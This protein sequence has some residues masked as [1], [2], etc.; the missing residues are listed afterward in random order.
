MEGRGILMAGNDTLFKELLRIEKI[1][2]YWVYIAIA[3]NSIPVLFALSDSLNGKWLFE[4]KEHDFPQQIEYELI[5]HDFL[6]ARTIGLINGK[7]I[8]DEYAMKKQ[9]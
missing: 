1:G 6:T 7:L 9:N 8:V 2:N 4:N 3:G 5:K